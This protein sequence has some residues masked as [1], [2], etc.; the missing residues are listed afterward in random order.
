[1][2]DWRCL[3]SLRGRAVIVLGVQRRLVDRTA[4]HLHTPRL[5]GKHTNSEL[6]GFLLRHCI[7]C[8]V[9]SLNEIWRGF[10]DRRVSI[11]AR[12]DEERERERER[13]FFR[14]L[15]IEHNT[16]HYRGRPIFLRKVENEIKATMCRRAPNEMALL[17]RCPFNTNRSILLQ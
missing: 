1:M 4:L 10:G 2:D 7:W 13:L 5:S 3:T 11:T 6:S 14:D 9:L 8:T 12:N 16:R 17:V 15:W